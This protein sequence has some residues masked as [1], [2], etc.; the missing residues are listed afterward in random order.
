MY[1]RFT[2]SNITVNWCFMIK[3]VT[4]KILATRSLLLQLLFVTLAFALMVTASG[5]FVNGMM[6]SYLRREAENIL[7]QTE[8]RILAELREPESVMIG[9]EKA[10]RDIIMTGGG[11]DD[12]R[13]YFDEVSVLL[14]SKNEGFLFDGFHGFFDAF[15]DTYIQVTGHEMP[16]DYDAK[17]RPWYEAAVKADGEI[18]HTSMYRSVGN[19]EY[20]IAFVC[21]IFDDDHQP[22][23]VIAMNVLIANISAFVSDMHI[24]ENGYGF[25][26]NAQF[27]LVAHPNP[28]YITG[29]MAEN[30][31][32]HSILL[33]LFKQGVREIYELEALGYQGDLMVFFCKQLE[34]G[35][36]LG[37]MTPRD[38]YYSDLTTLVWNLGILGA[39]L[40]SVMYVILIRID[41]KRTKRDKIYTTELIN[42][43]DTATQSNR[44]KGIFL[45]RM[46]HEIRTP[47]NAIS[48]ISEI[49]LRNNTLSQEAKEGYNKIYESGN[50]LLSIVNDILDYSKI[51]AGKLEITSGRYDIPSLINDT[52]QINRLR[53]DSKPVA[54]ELHLA[55]DTPLE[56][57]GDEMR[58]RQILNNLLSNAFKYT[59]TG[60]VALS[61]SA[62]P[63]DKD[64]VTL[65]FKIQDTGQ[66]MNED[67]LS[68]LFN[69]YTRFN[70]DT[71]R[72][73]TG[74]GLGMNITKRLV[75]MM[76]GEIFVE[77]EAGKGSAFTVHLPQTRCGDG[78]CGDEIA[79]RL[80]EFNFA[81]STISKQVH[82][83]H[84]H[85]PYGRVLVV[86]D[87][88]SN[89]YVAKGLL[90]PYGLQIE[91]ANS[92]LEAI[93]LIK[94]G[95]EYDI[96]FM[97]HMMPKMDGI[98]ATE[99]LRDLGYAHPIVALT[100]NAVVGQADMF[101]ACGFDEFLSKPIDSREM[102]RILKDLIRNRQSSEIIEAARRVGTPA[103]DAPVPDAPVPGA[104]VPGTADVSV[105]DDEDM[106]D[107]DEFFVMDA[108]NTIE[109][110]TGLMEPARYMT[111]DELELY[112]ITV[113]GIKS[114]LL[115][116]GEAGLSAVALDL[117]KAGK[118][119]DLDRIREMTPGLISA[120]QA[121]I[122]KFTV[123]E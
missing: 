31:P 77:S 85:M 64:T 58:I 14:Y 105:S 101:L 12:V 55:A 13:R 62:E 20:Q 37:V 72:S 107:I 29:A 83:L 4:N 59:D 33:D 3:S 74:T 89:L 51:D 30:S 104:P 79:V 119:R 8:L 70:L 22:L 34:N 65:I 94:D 45:A 6:R 5:V 75:E 40:M 32:G 68:R 17:T 121:L 84:E 48:S 102:D 21:R 52:V 53:Y 42:A 117:E 90:I 80:R 15:N 81:S 60:S 54:F 99:I 76:G 114:A 73:I 7:V 106:S 24:T 108:E 87:V 115:N 66:G 110:L 120:L 93:D 71:N 43:R 27:E 96:I 63:Y 98:Q 44:S 109:T 11:A 78:V 16:D 95:Q 91:T 49:Q 123:S 57:I 113:H 97:D 61:I 50:L 103:P 82:I 88:E 10:V 28:D 100:A 35:W 38:E 9:V 112:E 116:I 19:N 122:G 46:S 56:L 39:A 118:A 1:T 36:Y 69:E 92:G 111:D 2:G 41:Y 26:A 23:G 18:V 25:L 86:D 67:Q 47:M